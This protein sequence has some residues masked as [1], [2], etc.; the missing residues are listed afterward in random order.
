[1]STARVRRSWRAAALAGAI[2]LWA[3]GLVG[4][5]LPQARCLRVLDGDSVV[6]RLDG[7]E[8]EARLDGIDAP[9]AA[10]R[11]ATGPGAS[12]PASPP[13]GS[14]RSTPAAP[15]GT[16]AFSSGCMPAGSR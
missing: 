11:S 3:A 9:S 2:L 10:S 12:S 7:R 15:T 6:L 5:A 13:A 8:I 4:A 1:M 14:S 16:A